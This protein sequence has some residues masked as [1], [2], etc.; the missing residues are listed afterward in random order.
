MGHQFGETPLDMAAGHP[1]VKKVLEQAA[2]DLANA[3]SALSSGGSTPRELAL[4]LAGV[5][6]RRLAW[7]GALSDLAFEKLGRFVRSSRADQQACFAALLFW[8]AGEGSGEGSGEGGA[9]SPA[10]RNLKRARAKSSQLFTSSETM[11]WSSPIVEFLVFPEA[12]TRLLLRE[13]ES[14]LP[15]S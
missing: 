4:A 6:A 13:L 5:P 14:L 12:K 1:E 9:E 15:A 2:E 3:E 7:P 11:P 10:A 8:R